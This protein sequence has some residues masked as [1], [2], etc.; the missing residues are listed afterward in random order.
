MK[1]TKII[2]IKDYVCAKCEQKISDYW[3]KK[4]KDL[5]TILC[6]KCIKEQK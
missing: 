6:K 4:N 5:P 3:Y 1:N 2:I